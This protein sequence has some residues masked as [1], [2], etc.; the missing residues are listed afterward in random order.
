M[1]FGYPTFF[2]ILG[3]IKEKEIAQKIYDSDKSAG[4]TGGQ[5]CFAT[6][7]HS[8]KRITKFPQ[9]RM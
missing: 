2:S 6:S 5:V 7:S 4:K 9:T 3:E 1:A 8:T